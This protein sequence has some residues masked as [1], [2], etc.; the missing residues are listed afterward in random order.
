MR[1]TCAWCDACL[2][3]YAIGVPVQGLNIILMASLARFVA[4]EGATYASLLH[5]AAAKFPLACASGWKQNRQRIPDLDK[6]AAT[7]LSVT[8]SRLGCIHLGKL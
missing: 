4:E 1:R 6:L 2:G 3:L 7:L 8:V 5:A